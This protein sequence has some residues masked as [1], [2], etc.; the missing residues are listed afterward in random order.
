[1]QIVEN[2]ALVLKVRDPQRITSLIPCSKQIGDHEVLVRWGLEEAQVL[3]NLRIKGVPSPIRRVYNWPGMHRPFLHQITTA[4]FLTLNRRAFCFNSQGTGKTAAAIWASDYLIKTKRIRRV[5][6]VCP[7]SIMGSAWQADLFQFAMHRSCDIAHNSR[8][9][10]RIAVVES[11]VE[12]VIVNYDGVGII[13]DA[14]I[15]DGRFDLIIVDE[16]NAYK[17]HTTDRWK[18]LAKII[19]PNTWLWM[20]TGTPASQ[21]PTDAYG[22][23]KMV[24]PSRVPK[25]YGAFRDQV[26]R[27]ITRFK[28]VPKENATEVVFNVLQPAIRFSKEEC[29]DLP[30]MMYATREVPLTRQQEKYYNAMVQTQLTVAAGETVTAPTAAALLTKLL[31]ISSGAV[32]SDGKE[33]IEFDCAN[34]LQALREVIDE[35]SHKVLVFVPYTHSLNM[36][37]EWLNNHGYPTK[38]IDGSVPPNKRTEIFKQFQTEKDPRVLVIQPQAAS[39]GVTLHAAN[40]VVYWSPV[41]SVETYLQANARV[42]RAGQVNKVTIVHLEGSR[43][44]KKVYRMLQGKVDVHQ[45]LID[46]YNEELSE[47]NTDE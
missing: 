21:A 1:M 41:M 19:G 32:Y 13:A 17:T 26:M 36:V 34:R 42:H 3:K 45:K 4:E 25:F 47:E 7:V 27:Q 8:R 31:Q 33:V 23:A 10:K 18:A 46:L 29:L 38:I 40:V 9:E 24:S 6:V 37:A 14:V 20:M 16:A 11:D 30:D 43:I 5:L 15:A 28:W 2:K 44:E 39:H 22:L 35:A 12:Y